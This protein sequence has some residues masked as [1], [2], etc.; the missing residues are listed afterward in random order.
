MSEWKK[1]YTDILQKYRCETDDVERYRLEQQLKKVQEKL[2]QTDEKTAV[3][4]YFLDTG[5]L[6]FQYYDIQER[7]NQGAD[8]IV[9]IADRA[10]PGSVFEAL[11]N[12][13]KND[14][15]GTQLTFQTSQYQGQNHTHIRESNTGHFSG[16]SDNMRRDALLEQYLQRMDP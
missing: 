10:T 2:D 3:L 12:A 16:S 14:A 4:D 7:I 13:S 11:E 8:N 5:D 9:H 1:E 15:S 6:L